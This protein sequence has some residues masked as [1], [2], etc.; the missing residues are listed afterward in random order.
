MTTLKTSIKI[1]NFWYSELAADGGMG[2]DWNEVASAQREN[3]VSFTGSDASTSNYKNVLGGILE[4]SMS[5]GDKTVVWQ[6]ADL[7]PDVVA[8]FT[9]G[10]V[11]TTSEGV[12][13]DAPENENQ[14]IEKSVMFLTEKNVLFRLPRVRF[15]A[16]PAIN[17]D[18][19]HY[20]QINGV[21]L[22]PEKVGV[23]SYGYDVLSNPK[24]ADITEFDVEDQVSS[25]I[26]DDAIAVVMPAL[27]DV[28]ALV[29]TIKISLGAMIKPMSGAA[30]DFTTPVE[31][32][33]TSANGESK[34]FT[35]TVT[36]DS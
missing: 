9:G 12:S 2:S 13:F 11:T 31:Y 7:S 20:H 4:S 19:L 8:A 25:T 30:E 3:T 28:T 15:D 17:D 5:K 23:G 24:A 32:V 29:P 16:Y 34:T 6:L 14:Y 1:K 27:T 36:L 10:K 18:D 22:Q 33:V 35:V 26:T 21:V